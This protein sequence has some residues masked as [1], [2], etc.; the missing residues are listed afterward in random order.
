[1]SAPVSL[2]IG[3]DAVH[4]VRRDGVVVRSIP[5]TPDVP[6]QIVSDVRAVVGRPSGLVLVVGMA[7]QEIAEPTLP[8]IALAD[9]RTLLLRDADRY[10]PIHERAA[11]ALNGPLAFA[12][13]APLLISWARAFQPVARIRAVFASPSVAARVIGAGAGWVA[14]DTRERVHLTVESGQLK[15]ARRERLIG[16]APPTDGRLVDVGA[17]GARALRMIHEP[18]EHQLLDASLL[19][20]LRSGR[21]IR[22]LAAIGYA[23]VLLLA[24]VWLLDRWRATQLRDLRAVVATLDS[25]T[26]GVREAEARAISATTEMTLLDASDAQRRAPDA[27]LVVMAQLSAA[28]PSDALVQRLTFDG[29]QW[30]VEGT[31]DKAPRLIPL[32][33]G[34]A[35]F[36]DVRLASPTQRFVDAGR[37]RESFAITFRTRDA[38]R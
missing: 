6:E 5:W 19:Q 3:P 16:A 14:G 24:I 27:A 2:V 37:Q 9:Q 8:P 1:M 25:A 21:R 13:P 10:F 33:D 18:L 28:L 4:V 26:V 36:R 23:A 35:H 12:M 15:S 7:F 17:L 29:Q 38:G 31:A 30:R 22:R 11:V 34:N 32:L 20:R